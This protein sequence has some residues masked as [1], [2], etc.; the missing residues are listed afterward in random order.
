MG[1]LA[2]R[3]S[4]IKAFKER[5]KDVPAL[6]VDS[7]FFLA[8]DRTTH[9]SIRFDAAIKSEWALRAYERSSVDVANVSA[10]DLR[11]ISS[12]GQKPEFASRAQSFPMLKRLVSANI[13]PVSSDI[14]SFPKY[15]IREVAGPAAKPI[16][17]AIVGLSEKI[18]DPPAGFKI[19]DPVEAAKLVV[20]QARNSA[21]IVIVL[22]HFSVADSVRLARGVQGIDAVISGNSQ[23]NE[24]HFTPP[25][26]MNQTYILFTPYETRM[27]GELRFYSD[28]QGGFSTR[29]RFISLDGGVPDDAET[30]KTVEAARIAEEEAR[31]ASKE[32]LKDWLAAT[33][34]LSAGMTAGS[35]AAAARASVPSAACAS[36]HT[37]QYAKWSASRHARATDSLVVKQIE[38]DRSCLAC[39]ASG[40]NGIAA[41][42]AG[43]LPQLQNIHCESCHGPGGEHIK[44]PAKGYGKV[45]D[46][47]TNCAACHTRQTSPGFDLQTAWEKI[48]H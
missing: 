15:V 42:E 10:Q 38:F 20:P 3:V 7:G 46:L 47:K 44:N 25:L 5:F 12:S 13:E 45:A 1:G 22:A 41:G 29:A 2:R 39:H 16:K 6:A 36:C 27:L 33:R 40:N 31:R 28:G 37:E 19:T 48:K 11:Y 17:V 24:Q 30:Q 26:R 35:P 14:I 4:Y 23:A 32:M 34:S 18:A 43:S 9:G 21:D 8:G